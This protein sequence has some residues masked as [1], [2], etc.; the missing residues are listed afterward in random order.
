M[1]QW[2]RRGAVGCAAGL[3]V[4]AVPATAFAYGPGGANNGFGLALSVS[5]GIGGDSVTVSAA[6]GPCVPGGGAPISLVRAIPSQTP[7]TLGATAV[8]SAGGLDAATVVIP[9]GS[10]VGVYIMF[11]TCSGGGGSIDV[12]TA[13][14]VV[15]GPIVAGATGFYTPASS[16]SLS[17]H[18]ATAATRAAVQPALDAALAQAS[19]A[20]TVTSSS[21]SGGRG[22]SSSASGGRGASGGS[23][24]ASAASGGSGA[25]NAAVASGSRLAVAAPVL[26]GPA[27]SRHNQAARSHQIIIWAIVAAAVAAMTT[28]GLVMLRRRRPAAH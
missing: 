18:W 27:S 7:A 17:P 22:A 21:A 12:F 3:A 9:V 5:V 24:G 23:S 19:P 6:T 14:F 26:A 4:L 28:T 10:P 13:S 25:S 2:L 11:S 20:A 16:V 1:I 8:N 15:D